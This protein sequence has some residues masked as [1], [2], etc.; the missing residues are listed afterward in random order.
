MKGI[1]DCFYIL[2]VYLLVNIITN[3][4]ILKMYVDL[5]EKPIDKNCMN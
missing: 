2:E 4:L 5:S 1:P 3:T